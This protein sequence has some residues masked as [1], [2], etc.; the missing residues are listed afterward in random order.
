[1]T[2]Q[3]HRVQVIQKTMSRKK[4]DRNKAIFQ[5]HKAV[6]WI[7]LPGR[8]KTGHQQQQQEATLTSKHPFHHP[9]LSLYMKE[10]SLSQ[11]EDCQLRK[12]MQRSLLEIVMNDDKMFWPMFYSYFVFVTMLRYKEKKTDS[13]MWLHYMWQFFIEG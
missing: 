13:H 11:A 12:S 1:M 6:R 5:K 8:E 2:E 4:K 10:M 9:E 3:C 7:Q